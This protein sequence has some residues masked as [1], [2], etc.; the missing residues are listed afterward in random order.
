MSVMSFSLSQISGQTALFHAAKEGNLEIARKLIGAG[1]DVLLKDKVHIARNH[2]SPCAVLYV[3]MCVPQT[4]KTALNVAE[5]HG[6]M[7]V[8]EVLSASTHSPSV[9]KAEMKSS[10]ADHQETEEV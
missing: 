8:Y 10:G 3:C 7:E 6:K 2:Y 9:K 4:G 5:I 1:A